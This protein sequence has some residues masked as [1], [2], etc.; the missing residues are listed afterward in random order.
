MGDDTCDE[1]K[2]VVTDFSMPFSSMVVFLTKLALASIPALL[3]IWLVL[4]V[5][6][7]AAMFLFGGFWGMHG[8]FP[9]ASLF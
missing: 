6:M 3:I 4:M 9:P 2:V 5:L 1:R 8:P 7:A